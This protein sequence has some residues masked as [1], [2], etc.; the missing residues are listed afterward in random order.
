MKTRVL[1]PAGVLAAAIVGTAC[2]PPPAPPSST[3]TT[4]TVKPTTPPPAGCATASNTTPG[5]DLD[6]PMSSWGVNGQALASAVIGNVV[7]VG[8]SFTHAVSPAGAMSAKSNLA[9]FCLANGALLTTFTANFGGGA[10]NALAT[11]GTNLF[12]G[13]NFTT[14]NGAPVNR[15]VKLTA[16]GAKVGAFAPKTIPAQVN[17]LAYDSVHGIVYAAGEFGKLGVAPPASNLDYV[18]NAAGFNATSGAWTKWFAGASSPVNSI[19]VSTNGSNVW[20]GGKFSEVKKPD[21][22]TAG[23]AR[24]SIAKISGGP[25]GT[26]GTLDSIDYGLSLVTPTDLAV[27]PADNASLFAAIGTGSAGTGHR[28]ISFDATGVTTWDDNNFKGNAQALEVVGT[29][30]YEGFLGGYQDGTGTLT[31]N[32]AQYRVLAVDPSV[33][34]GN[35]NHFPRP[36]FGAPVVTPAPTSGVFDV[37]SG[38]NQLV[39]VGDFTSMGTTTNLHGVAIFA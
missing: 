19:A 26:V 9:A 34:P 8:G 2:V 32:P 13:G 1:L 35:L 14:L 17:D 7:Y 10:V 16:A 30:L 21:Q 33:G 24:V 15:L 4:T 37:T 25:S 38:K 12:V 3:T 20:I 39:V 27:N 11:D 23:S 28:V 18:G 31:L 6:N 5:P 22:A 29:R 36:N